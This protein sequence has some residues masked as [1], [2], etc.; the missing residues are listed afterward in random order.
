MTNKITTL[1]NHHIANWTVLYVKLH[2]YHWYVKGPQFFTLHVKF[3]EFYEEAAL[4][5]DELAERVLAL[6]AKPVATMKECLELS[7][8]TEA[9][10]QEDAEQMVQ[11]LSTDF[12]T[13]IEQLQ[14]DM[15][16]AQ[17]TGDETTADM[18]LAIHT[19]LQTH[20]WMLQAFLQ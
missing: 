15:R 12:S 7:S 2:N 18:L 5:V 10:G 14:N 3:Q 6:Q 19:Q 9:T 20:V 8:V 11:T 13:I 4:H 1:L 17:E 16:T